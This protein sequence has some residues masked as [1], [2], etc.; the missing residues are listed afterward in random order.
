MIPETVSQQGSHIAAKTIL[1][2]HFQDPPRHFFRMVHE[3]LPVVHF[4]E[5]FD[6][7]RRADRLQMLC[8]GPG[9]E[10]FER[11]VPEVDIGAGYGLQLVGID[12][13]V[14]VQDGPAAPEGIHL[15]AF[16]QQDI[17]IVRMEY[18]PP[19]SRPVVT[20]PYVRALIVSERA[21]Q[22]PGKR[23]QGGRIQDG[24]V[25]DDFVPLQH[26]GED[27]SPQGQA[28]GTVQAASPALLD[29]RNHLRSLVVDGGEPRKG[30][31]RKAIDLHGDDTEPLLQQTDQREKNLIRHPQPRDEQQRGCALLSE[32]LEIHNVKDSHSWPN[33][34]MP[35][36]S[37]AQPKQSGA[38]SPSYAR[39]RTRPRFAKWGLAHLSAQE[40][41][42]A[43][44]RFQDDDPDRWNNGSSPPAGRRWKLADILKRFRRP[45]A[46]GGGPG[47][48][49]PARPWGQPR[50]RRG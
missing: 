13:L 31:Q 18:P 17:E 8:L 20:S 40:A 45:K 24:M 42:F 2:N 3:Q 50:Q 33:C 15:P 43:P 19:E 4:G 5:D 11:A 6:V 35:G 41:D 29:I 30:S 32:F 46:D 36:L 23:Q 26:A 39:N 49:P 25:D 21:F 10:R 7:G 48:L 44:D 16:V 47:G 12:R 28:I 22:P 27:L 37:F 1:L 9:H 38:L 34:Q 14:P